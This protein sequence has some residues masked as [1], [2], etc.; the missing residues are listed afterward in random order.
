[1]PVPEVNTAWFTLNLNGRTDF[2]ELLQ[3]GEV[4]SAQEELEHKQEMFW[5]GVNAITLG[6]PGSAGARVLK[7]LGSGKILIPA[8]I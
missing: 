1:M 4:Y 8:G 3:P 6:I 2:E 5:K 7:G